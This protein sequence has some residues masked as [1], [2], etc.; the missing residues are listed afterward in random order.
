LNSSEQIKLIDDNARWIKSIRDQE[1]YQLNFEKYFEN[2]T[3]N[4]KESKRF[5]KL[6]DYQTDLTFEPLS[7]ELP[8]M[9]QDSV[10]KINRNRWHKNLSKDIYMEEALNVLNDLNNSDNSKKT[11]QLKN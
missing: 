1:V 5:D 7:Y 11:T 4:E 10:F 9:K 3:S 2:I 6:L 8:I